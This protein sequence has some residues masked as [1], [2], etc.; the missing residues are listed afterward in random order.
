[1]SWYRYRRARGPAGCG[2]NVIVAFWEPELII[3]NG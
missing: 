1:V 3:R 2:Q